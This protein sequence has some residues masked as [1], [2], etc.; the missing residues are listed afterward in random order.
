IV[1][2]GFDRDLDFGAD[3]VGR[4][5]QNWIREAGS[6]EIEKPAET[7]DFGTGA[8][9]RGRAHQRLDQFHQ[10]VASIDVDTSAR[11]ACISHEI[12]NADGR[13]LLDTL[14]FARASYVGIAGCASRPARRYNLP[15][16]QWRAGNRISRRGWR[17]G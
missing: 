1:S 6:F 9:P 5:N 16:K 14:A 10:A 2:R 3:A 12:T 8:G 7:A 11:V 15:C 13:A 4:G 17:M